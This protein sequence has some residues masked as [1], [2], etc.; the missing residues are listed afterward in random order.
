MVSWEREKDLKCQIDELLRREELLWFQKAKIQ[1]RLE[2]DRCSRF[3]FMTTM[4]RRKSN[5]IDCLKLDNGE[6]IY[7]RNQIGNLFSAR[8]ESV[9]DSPLQPLSFDLSNIVNPVITE[10]DNADLLRIPSWEEVRN[11]VFSMGAFKA[12]GPDGMSA[13]FYK[14]YWNIVGWDLVA[15]VREFFMTNSMAQR[16]NESFIVL[17]P[18]KPNP[19]RLN[20]SGLSRFA[21]LLIEWLLKSLLI[22]LSLYLIGWSALLRMPLFQVGLSMITL[23]LCKRRFIP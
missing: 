17:I 2:G 13:L 20:H 23:F 21:M 4:I 7:S 16:F 8:F 1:W 6:W 3:F 15:A 19:T 10:E 11:V 5:R 14:H 18:K 22:G 9:F 12:P